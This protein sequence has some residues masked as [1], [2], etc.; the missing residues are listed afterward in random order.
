MRRESEEGQPKN[1]LILM[2]D[3]HQRQA[4]GAYGHAAVRSPN[5]DRL[6][7]TGTRFTN[8]YCTSPICVP[9]R[10]S[11]ATGRYVHELGTWDNAAPYVGQR[12]S[13]GHR[14]TKQ[15]YAVITVGKL[16]YRNAD[17]PTGFP[18]QRI[19]LHIEGEE[20]D[21]YA[22][23]RDNMPA[24]T[25]ARE[26]LFECGNGDSEYT[27]Y[28]RTVAAEA[29]HFIRHEARDLGK[30][31]ALMVS[32]VTP[33]FPWIV[34]EP[35]F[36][37]YDRSPDV[38]LPLQYS[39][40]ER[41][42]H[43][44][45]EE[46][47]RVF[48][49]GDSL[50]EGVVKKARASYYGLCSFMDAQLGLVLDALRAEGL[51]RTT[52]IVY[53]SDHGDTLGDH[54]LWWKHT[55]YEGSV[56]VPLIVA[57]PGIPKGAVRTELVS[58]IDLFPTILR[59]TGSG[60]D[61]EDADLPGQVFDD[62]EDPRSVHGRT[63]LAEYHA[64]GAVAGMFMLRK[65]TMKYIHYVGYEPQLFDLQRDPNELEDLAGESSHRAIR[66]SCEEALR[67]IV[68]P[69]EVDRTAREDQAQRI[70]QHGG[71]DAVLKL[72]EQAFTPVPS[73]LRSP[74]RGVSGAGEGSSERQGG[75]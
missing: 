14:L 59:W 23:V 11:I 15:G 75:R 42:M 40:N 72:G 69:D 24:L 39:Q 30:P 71:R 36:E 44:V 25:K 54:G 22:L 62:D 26:R 35:Y 51:D 38:G 17:D 43:P 63:L 33:H 9:A 31:W 37:W 27:E 32:F 73:D 50:P 16:H 12:A 6:A 60:M 64:R 57:G 67:D 3:Q 68:D 19:P 7:G 47:R 21:V 10:A 13:W 58:H 74:A 4:S 53:T 70:D 66:T 56:G 28:D 2:S 65:G 41:P 52:R 5:I 29:G 49:L 45:L 55:M 46:M 61:P 18:D 8:A 48:G 1:L 20:G 34:P